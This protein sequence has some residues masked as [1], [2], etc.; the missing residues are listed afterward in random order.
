MFI[1]GRALSGW[2]ICPLRRMLSRSWYGPT[3]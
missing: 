2:P 1:G 3:R